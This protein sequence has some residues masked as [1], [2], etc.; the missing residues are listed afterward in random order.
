MMVINDGGEKDNGGVGLDNNERRWSQRWG[1]KPIWVLVDNWWRDDG[2]DVAD[3]GRVNVR[4]A[5]VREIRYGFY[6]GKWQTTNIVVRRATDNLVVGVDGGGC[7]GERE[8][9][10]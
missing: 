2:G 3:N 5:D 9:E 6:D 7:G 1:W 8:G 10:G 4:E